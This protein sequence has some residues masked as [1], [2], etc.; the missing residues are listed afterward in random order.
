M[1][2]DR[3][4]AKTGAHNGE[5]IWNITGQA[6]KSTSKIQGQE[7]LFCTAFIDVLQ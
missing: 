4:R 6:I 3:A 2:V 1:D 5:N 7:M